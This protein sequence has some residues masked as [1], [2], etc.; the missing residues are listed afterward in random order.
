MEMTP[1]QHAQ[2]VLQNLSNDVSLDDILYQMYALKNV[3]AGKEDV[4]A[5]RC[6]THE[7]VGDMIAQWSASS[8][9]IAREIYVKSCRMNGT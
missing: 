2:R 7:A 4:Q 5:G 6:H 8:G 9:Q 3:L 1:K